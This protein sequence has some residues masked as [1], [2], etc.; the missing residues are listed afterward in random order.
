MIYISFTVY[1][2]CTENSKIH[3]FIIEKQQ[4]YRKITENVSVFD[5]QLKSFETGIEMGADMEQSRKFTISKVRREPSYSMKATHYHSYHEL[6]YI[7][8]GECNLFVNHNIYKLMSGDLG[9]IPAGEIHKTN[10]PETGNHQRISISFYEEDLSLLYEMLGKEQ[11]QEFLKCIVISIPEK[12]RDYVEG[13]TT[14][15]LFENEHPDSLSESFIRVSFQELVLFLLRCQKYEENVIK[16]ID[17]DN[18]LIQEVATYIYDNYDKD[19]YLDE[20]AEQFNISRSYLSKKFKA[21]TGVGFKEYL[22]NVRI[23]HACTLL[24]ET[25]KSITDIA[26]SCGFNDSNYFGDA[27]RHIKGV[28][29]NKYRKNKETV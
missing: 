1:S 12:R 27:F 22:V 5:F 7:V 23:R 11:M 8:S 24:L 17:V 14:K 21:I 6:I 26:F 20:V 19:V 15:L 4:K 18:S 13:I 2:I 3:L 25:D 28:S 9:I 10:Y 29:P 16:E